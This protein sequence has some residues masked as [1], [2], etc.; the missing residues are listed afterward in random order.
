[1][2]EGAGSVWN[3]G[4]WHWESKTYT[5]AMKGMVADGLAA[6]AVSHDGIDARVTKVKSVTGDVSTRCSFGEIG[7]LQ[8]AASL[9]QECR[10][11][12]GCGRR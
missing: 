12:R 11:F 8:P 4:S 9:S 6:V 5:Q 7:L 10:T 2:A 3:P 1:M